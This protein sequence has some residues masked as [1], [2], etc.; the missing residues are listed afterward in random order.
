M[1]G[2]FKRENVFVL[3]GD[4]A[5]PILWYARGVKAMKARKLEDPTSWS[6]FGAIHGIWRELW[7]FY[8]ITDAADPAPSPANVAAYVDQCQHQSWYFLPWHRGYLIA[9]ENMIRREIELQ[10]G[11]HDSWALPYWNYFATGQNVLPPAFRTADWPDGVGDN[12][13]FVEQRWGPLSGSTPFDVGSQ[14]N[15]DPIGDPDFTGPGGGGSAGFGGLETGFN[16]GGGTNGRLEMDPHNILHGLVGG[17][18]PTLTLPN[19]RPLPGLMSNPRTA[20]LDPIFYLHHCNLDR[21]WESWNSFPLGKPSTKPTDWQNPTNPKWLD[22]PASIGEREFA[23]PNPDKSKWVYKP[24][25]MQDIAGLG[26]EYDDLNPGAVVPPVTLAARMAAL[27]IATVAATPIGGLTM[28]SQSKVEMIGASEGGVSLAGSGTMRSS[29]KTEPEARAKVSESLSA[30]AAAPGVPDRVFLNL[31]N[32]TGL[33]DAVIFQV[34][35]GLPEGADP[36]ANKQYLAGSV[37]LFGVSQASDP[38][39]QHAGN[40]INCTLEITK[41]VDQLHLDHNF[42]VDQLSVDFVP[43]GSIPDAAKVKI[44][45]IS[46]YRQFE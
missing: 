7:D 33:H 2:I 16:H 12:P 13:L 5:D 46:I 37:S 19:G 32:V 35:V 10:N 30:A 29:V 44:G 20:G 22:G 1:S 26:Y 25:Q 28:A 3:G 11:P 9:I 40:G 21:L 39:G 45:R 14:T 34:Y 18:H 36:A 31:E 6:F 15:L 8:K 43:F 27:G 23:M 17:G 4:W 41:V 38:A 24:E 42:D